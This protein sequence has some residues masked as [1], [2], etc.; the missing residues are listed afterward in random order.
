[1]FFLKYSFFIVFQ[2]SVHFPSRLQHGFLPAQYQWIYFTHF[3]PPWRNQMMGP[4]NFVL[5]VALQ[6]APRAVNIG[7]M[8]LSVLWNSD[9]C[10]GVRVS[11]TC[12]HCEFWRLTGGGE[13]DWRIWYQTQ[14]NARRKTIKAH[15]YHSNGITTVDL[16]RSL[17]VKLG[18]AG[19]VNFASHGEYYF[20]FQLGISTLQDME[21]TCAQSEQR[22]IK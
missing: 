12:G 8:N 10:S 18:F 21:Y 20:N 19:L 7:K 16:R 4:Q 14:N 3:A 6:M 5:Q 9:Y 11:T 15:L 1:M 2:T 17:K 22:K 13:I